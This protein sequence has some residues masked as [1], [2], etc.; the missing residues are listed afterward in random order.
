MPFADSDIDPVLRAP[1]PALQLFRMATTSAATSF[2]NTHSFSQSN[3]SILT[4]PDGDE[5]DADADILPHGIG[6]NHTTSTTYSGT[7]VSPEQSTIL[8]VNSQSRLTTLV[9]TLKG[10]KKLKM[11]SE[12]DLE[13]YCTVS[14]FDY[15]VLQDSL[16][17]CN[18]S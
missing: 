15:L 12:A 7:T 3:N 13:R 8:P 14:L 16:I 11:K 17:L 9:H 18:R 1:D 10:I 5:S 2:S 6:S 4:N